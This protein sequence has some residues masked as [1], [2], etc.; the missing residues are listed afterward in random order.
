V[1][2]AGQA[3]S[4]SLAGALL[5]FAANALSRQPARLGQPVRS[6]AEQ[7]GACLLPGARTLLPR[8]SVQEAT[9]MCLA[10]SAGF[11][12]A[13]PAGEYA[14]GHVSGAV[15]VPPGEITLA[16]LLQLERFRTVVVYDGDPTGGGAEAVASSLRARG[17]TDVRILAGA[18]PAWL[19]AGGPGES[20][21]C[22]A[23]AHGAGGLP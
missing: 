7:A 6:A 17:M 12:D 22:A 18:W 20:G 10:C 3:L 11:V 8:I 14:A 13:R 21:P 9:P 1:R 2:I 16:A 23:C 4:L 19:A 15:H 5:G